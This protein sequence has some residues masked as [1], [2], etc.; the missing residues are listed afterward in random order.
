MFVDE[1][2]ANTSMT[3]RYGRSAPGQRVREGA[4]AGHWRTLTMLGAMS[5]DGVLA[6]MTIPEPT[7][8]DIF[9][10][11]VEQVLSPRLQPGQVVVMDNLSAHKVTGVREQIAAR[12]ARLLY[13]PPYS[14]DFNPIEKCWAK[15]KENLRA[16]KARS[17]PLLDEAMAQALATISAQNAQAWFRHSGYG[18]T[19]IMKPV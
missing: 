1:S 18:D 13:L 11:F 5:Q 6:S 3:R 7:D 16:L 17:L 4:P 12:G 14:P 10:A 8:G 19:A 2:G 9:L 15:I